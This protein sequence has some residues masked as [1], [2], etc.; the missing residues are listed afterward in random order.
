MDLS[1]HACQLRRPEAKKNAC[2]VFLQ[3]RKGDRGGY[4]AETSFL[5]THMHTLRNRRAPADMMAWILCQSEG[6]G[7]AAKTA[8][9][10]SKGIRLALS[11]R[12]LALL[13]HKITF[14]ALARP[15]LRKHASVATQWH[16]G[17]RGRKISWRVLFCSA[18]TGVQK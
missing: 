6:R 11:L 3:P 7:A 4:R 1:G 2:T 18:K 5:C 10:Y 8:N 14:A 17:Q 13:S 9:G 15:C 12:V 16:T